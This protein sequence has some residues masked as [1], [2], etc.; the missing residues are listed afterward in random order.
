VNEISTPC[1]SVC[2]L[3]PQG[4]YCQTCRRSIDEIARWGGM[5]ESERKA[6]MA[7]LPQRRLDAAAD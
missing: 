5:S 4:R 3:D 2:N 6:I 7:I 1:R